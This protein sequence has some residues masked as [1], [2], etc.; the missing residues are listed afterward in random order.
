MSAWHTLLEQPDVFAV[1]TAFQPG[2]PAAL[3]KESRRHQKILHD[4]CF[5]HNPWLVQYEAQ[6]V[7]HCRVLF[8]LVEENKLALAHRLLKAAPALQS[9]SGDFP[10]LYALDTA[11][12]LGDLPLLCALHVRGLGLATT[13]AMDAA[14]ANG[15]L[16][17]VHFLHAHRREG[18]SAEAMVKAWKGQHT[19]V[20]DFLEATYPQF[21]C[22]KKRHWQHVVRAWSSKAKG[23][24]VAPAT[25][26]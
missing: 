7:F 25:G 18:C 4:L 24:L 19:D 1:V 20:V 21:A 15:R 2:L 13:G 16:D 17:I 5:R 9:P 14:A 8:K 12:R 26:A 11:A 22:S 10:Y 23:L 6:P 3:A